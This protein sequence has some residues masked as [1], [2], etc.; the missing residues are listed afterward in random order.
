[1]AEL[2]FE[3][4]RPLSR[5][6][7]L[8]YVWTASLALATAGSGGAVLWFAYPRFREGE[9]GG[10]FPL[11]MVALPE[12]GSDPEPYQEGRF[13]LVNAENGVLALYMVCT[14]LGCLYKWVPN[15]NRFICPCHTS[16]YTREGI[17]ISG[18]T[19][20]NLDQFV[21][22]ALDAEDNVIAETQQG[23]AG[24]DRAAGAPLRVPDAAVKVLILT[25]E[26]VKG[27]PAT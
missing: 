18:P 12:V 26:R 8:F 5:R 11:D 1:M 13:W 4:S 17:K 6:E 14:H 23:N 9:F 25:G 10:K 21:I 2:A 20:R 27:A 22:Q 7:F 24:D 3:Q 16:M 19:S 15:S